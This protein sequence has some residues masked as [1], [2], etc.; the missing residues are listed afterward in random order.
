MRRGGRGGA[1]KTRPTRHRGR[2]RLERLESRQVLCAT[3]LFDQLVDPATLADWNDRPPSLEGNVVVDHADS[4]AVSLAASTGTLATLD[5]GV[6]AAATAANGMPILQGRPSAPTAIYLDFDGE[7][8]NRPYDVDGDPA[9]FNATEA[10]TITEAWRQVSVYVSMFDVDV[11]TEKPTVPFAWHVSSPDI[12]GGYSYVG[13]FPNSSPQSFNNAGDARSRVSGIVHELGHNFGLWHQSDYDLLGNKTKEYSSGFDSL[14]GPLM[15]VDYAQ[16]VH[17]WFI[18]HPSNS[19]S[20]LQD[21]IAVIASK[22]KARQPAGGDGF[23]AD[24]FGGT[25]ATARALDVVAGGRSIAG[26]IERMADVDAFSFTSAGGGAVI[27]VVPTKPSGLDAK[28]EVYDASG[29]LV[30]A[31]D[32]ATNE[33]QVV[34]PPG[35]GTWY[36]M[37]S[38]HGDYGDL[39]MYDLTV[40]DLPVGWSTADVGSTGNPGSARYDSA[41]DTFTV[42]GS[43]ADVWGTADAFR[44]VW[45]TLT[46]D[47]SIVARVVQ[48]QNTHAWSKVGVEIRE[49]LAAGSKH[50]AMVTSATSGPQLVSRTSTGGTSTAVNGTAAAFTPTWVRLVRAGSLITASR[51]ADGTTWT[52]VGS[53]SVTM[54]STVFIGLLACSHDTTKLNEAKFSGVAL[55]GALNVAEPEN[56]LPVPQGVAVVRGTGTALAVSWQGVAGAAGYAIERSAN[57]VDFTAAGS[58]SASATSWTD[59]SLSTSMRFFYRVRATDPAGRSGA[60]GI[61][62]AVN[63]P[64]AVTAAAVTALTISDLVLNWRDTSGETGYRIERSNDNVTFTQVATVGT[65]VPSHAVSGLAMGSRYWFRITPM[66]SFGDSVATVI[67]GSTRLAS[68][69]G[70]AFTTKSATAIGLTWSAL[71]GATGYRIERSSDGSAFATLTTVGSVLTYSDTSVA[72]LGEYYYRVIGVSATAEGLNPTLP[73]FTAVPAAT[74]L[75]A[76]WTAADIGNVSGTGASGSSGGVFTVVS[77]GADIWSTADAFRYTYQPLVGDGSIV[78]R[79]ATV[80]NTAGWA[81]IGVMIRE[82][83]AV[84]SRHAMV[85]VSPSNSVAM[86]YRSSTGGTSTS[87]AGP[88]GKVAPYWVRLVRSGNVFTGSISADGAAWFSVGSVTISMGSSVLVGLSANSNI[89]TRLNTST[90]DNVSV[91]NAAPTI[92]TAAAAAPATVTGTTT[93]VS[94]LGSDDHGEPNLS[95][96][97]TATGPAAVSFSP[98]GTNAAKSAVA[99]FV[100]PGAYTLTATIT[101]SGGRTAS[102][103]VNVN[104]VSQLA[105]I[106]VGP[107]TAE[108]LVGGTRLFTATGIDQFGAP[109]TVQ[110]AIA[111]SVSGGGAITQEG[112]FTAPESATSSVITAA[113]GAIAGGAQVTALAEVV[114]NVPAG[115]TAVDA[116][117]WSGSGPFRKRGPGTL[118]LSGSNAVSGGLIV[119]EGLVVIRD[120]AALGGGVLD[121]WAAGRVVLDVGTGSVGIT[122]LALQ[123]GA[124]LDLGSGRIGI[125]TGG[126]SEAD[127]RRWLVSGRADGSWTGAAGILS[128]R[129]SASGGTRTIGYR[130]E[131]SGIT[132]AFVAAGDLNLDGIVDILDMSGMLSGPLS[133]PSST[134]SWSAGDFNYDGGFDALDVSE[135]LAAAVFGAGWYLGGD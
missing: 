64:A 2:L 32:G 124:V 84:N 54:G 52:A 59:S 11:T 101:D 90:F 105:G 8:S 26:I 109:L 133:E 127:V 51:S 102:S 88:T 91:S 3:H 4:F 108:V 19:A 94:V 16:S 56:G 103:A 89:T 9:T 40:A 58:A 46:G 66:S 117:G 5:G 31:S 22:I 97:W 69:G 118:V 62:A 116:G 93:A 107:A 87:I 68:V 55:T 70:L 106:V 10:A 6:V 18:G 63:R 132:I 12:S 115:Q 72:P 130:T 71:T 110:P 15:G 38:S 74:P 100:K 126:F 111:W 121:V 34:L 24:D 13:V 28:L 92:A 44:F 114:A 119:E 49:T 67:S 131:P 50:V 43:G 20:G 39:G 47:G 98:T 120:P 112:L 82:S 14:H 113:V 17:K 79:V 23:R 7:G 78:A 33:Q 30:A 61:V 104:V 36:V 37:V 128:T 122:S 65:N 42:S 83:T 85:V 29:T 53:V 25:I 81:K 80:E 35:T 86:Q 77:S 76:P 48:N 135:F 134:A 1:R 99:T 129:A 41:A 123:V 27:S 21:D 57:G 125:A 95:Y 45:Q 75:P 73:I 60:S 96:A